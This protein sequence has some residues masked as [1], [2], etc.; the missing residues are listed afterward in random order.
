MKNLILGTAGHVDHGKTSLIKTLTGV[1]LDTHKQEKE[2]G[3]T[4]NLGFTKLQ[5]PSGSEISIID[6]PGHQDFINKMVS[7]SSSVDMVLFVIAADSSVMPQ[8]IEHL[9]ILELLGIQKGV[10]ALSRADLVDEEMLEIVEEEVKELVQKSFLANADIIPV[11]SV[12]KSGIPELLNAIEKICKES[13]S[14]DTSGPFRMFIDRFFSIKGAGTVVTGSALGGK[15]TTEQ[16][17]YLIPSE[18]ELKIRKIEMHSKEVKQA[19]AGNRTSINIPNLSRNDFKRGMLVSD[20]PIKTTRRIDAYIRLLDNNCTLNKWSTVQLLFGTLQIQ[21]KIQLL[22]K[23]KLNAK[24]DAFVQIEFPDDLAFLQ[25]DRFIIRKTSGNITLGGGIVLDPFA[26]KHRKRPQTLINSLDNLIDDPITEFISLTI[27]RWRMPIDI[28]TLSEEANFPS[29]TI[30]SIDSKLLK[31]DILIYNNNFYLDKETDNNLTQKL[32]KDLRDLQANPDNMKKGR[33]L[34][35]IPGILGITNLH[36]NI[37]F[38]EAFLNQKMSED[39][40]ERHD[41]LW[42]I[43]G[44]NREL[45]DSN[46]S[47]MSL[48]ESYIRENTLKVPAQSDIEQLAQKNKILKK[49][50]FGIIELLLKEKTIYK[51]EDRY[52]HSITVEKIRPII[53]E[54]LSTNEKGLTVAEFRDL[55]NANRKISLTL[56]A[57]YDNEGST[58][59]EGNVRTITDFGREFLNKQ[60]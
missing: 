21:A 7:G 17:L 56:L 28:K 35:E 48:I 43:S 1:D 36:N 32:T 4:I 54:E 59:W 3:I 9:H 38:T 42:F 13:N 16:P 26:L 58:K 19:L 40:I 45:T 52:I 23:E 14:K 24:E 2:R 25:D 60:N 29:K 55:I 5:L 31:K 37:N 18:K 53:L 30:H 27:K 10:I 49:D 51:V 41:D 22:N 50:L 11:S 39:I 6:V 8:T 44:A 57:I 12:T 15:I 47:S 20:R 33:E 34:N 46:K